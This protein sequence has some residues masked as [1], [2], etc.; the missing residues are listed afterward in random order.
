MK[1]EFNDD[2]QKI[3]NSADVVNY[4]IQCDICGNKFQSVSNINGKRYCAGCYY[5][6]FMKDN[7]KNEINQLKEQLEACQEARKFEAKNHSESYKNLF[8]KCANE[9]RELKQQLAERD[10]RI[11]ELEKE[12]GYILFEDGYDEKGKEVHRQVYKTYNQAFN[13]QVL[14][15]KKL[16]RQLAEKDK[17]IERLK[18]KQELTFI[19]SKEDYF[20]RCNLLE[21]ANIKLQFT[22]TQL[23][24]SELEK[25]LNFI[26]NV[27]DIALKNCSLN[28]VY[29]DQILDFIDQQ[30][31]DLKGEKQ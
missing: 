7:Q 22:Q 18:T 15:T 5:K 13:E 12:N 28:N 6:T 29:Y 25:T 10:K 24:I 2:S 26:E 30:I 20:Q 3:C 8:D 17:E 16:R 23:A 19:H 1:F 31:N 27:F 21:E 9:V 11:A 14:E 4:G